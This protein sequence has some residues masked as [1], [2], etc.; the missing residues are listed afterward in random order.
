LNH[1][2]NSQPLVSVV[3]LSHN[4]PE[5]LGQALSSILR[6]TY[7]RLEILVVDN[8]SPRSPE[9]RALV[10]T[11]P[12]VRFISMRQNSG[13]TGGM[14][15]GIRQ[16][17]GAYIYL[18]E[19][20][21]V[22]A[23]DAI[24]HMVDYIER[25]PQAA[26]VSGAHYD[27]RGLLICAGGSVVLGPVFSQ[28]AIGRDTPNE[29]V[30]L[31]PFC[32]TYAT[33]AMML[34]RRSAIEEL[35]VLHHDFFMY[36]EDIELCL[37]VIRAGRNVVIVPDAKAIT[38]EDAGFSRSDA[39]LQFHK[40]KNL[41][42]T[43]LLHAPLTSLPEFFLRYAIWNVIRSLFRDP[44]STLTL[45]RAD[46]W[47]VLNTPRLMRDRLRYFF[48]CASYSDAPQVSQSVTAPSR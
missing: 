38:L 2:S 23:P 40:A 19:D 41:L 14:N 10:A 11:L 3:I 20:D 21:M 9:I 13:Y 48:N 47:F 8:P 27:E 37:R 6:Q 32:A 34:L 18:T 24:A 5:Y 12:Q 33:G 25:D 1:P 30:P 36:C 29:A 26:I 43:Y 44:R 17:R 45:L 22:T 16:S 42:A 35:G 31:G 4:R 39:V 7:S 15:E 28:L 46:A